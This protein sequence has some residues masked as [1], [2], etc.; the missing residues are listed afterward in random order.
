MIY[1][2]ISTEE[3][4]ILLDECIKYLIFKLKNKGAAQ[5]LLEGVSQIYD[6]LETNPYV[7]KISQDYFMKSFEYHE[8]KVTGMDYVIIYKIIDKN[9]CILGIFHTL[10]NYENK[11]MLFWKK[12]IF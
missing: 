3:M 11:I 2:I 4:E 10:E 1:N 7:Y 5:H 6:M 8:A 12:D 9:V